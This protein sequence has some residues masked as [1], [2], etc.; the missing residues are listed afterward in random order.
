MLPFIARRVGY[1]LIM[2][3]LI[4][5]VS[6]IIIDLPPSDYLTIKMLQLEAQ[7]DT[8]A[9]DRM[10]ALR[11][12]YALDQPLLARYGMWASH[13]I[14]GDFGDSF[15]YERPVS[16][17][18][19]ERLILTVALAVATLCITWIVAIPLGVYSAVHQYSLGDQIISVVSF[20]G[21]GLPGFLVALLVLYVAVVVLNQDVGGLFSREFVG[22]PW[23]LARVGD[24]LKHLWLPAVISSIT[25]I[26][27]LIR[28]M[29][30]NL[31]D[32]LRLPY[33]EAARARGLTAR[34]VVW[35]HAVRTA[36]TPLIVILGS[37]ALPSIITGSALV[38][39]VL[40]LPTIAPLY[41]VALQK[42]DMFLAGTCIVFFALLLLAGNLLADLLIDWL[43]PRIRLG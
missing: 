41:V 36:L 5:F 6:F 38:A 20:I 9:Q 39:I 15:E 10:N 23:S 8:S 30:G 21:L 26:G 14:Q 29:R 24:L 18:L 35:K 31:L 3:L 43:D 33:V 42:Q 28:I 27:S 32:T 12:R 13:F 1:S 16:D 22:A 34:G 37:E 19:R 40:N 4:S 25:T 11:E 2:V 17:M 7:G